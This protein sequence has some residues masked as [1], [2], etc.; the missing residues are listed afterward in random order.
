M[1][2]EMGIMLVDSQVIF[3]SLHP[4]YYFNLAVPGEGGSGERV[5]MKNK[6]TLRSPQGDNLPSTERDASRGIELY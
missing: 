3:P 5:Y 4:P 6:Q 1:G 2:C